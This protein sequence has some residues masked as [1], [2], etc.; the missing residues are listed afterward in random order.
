METIDVQNRSFVVRWLKVQKGDTIIFQLKPLKRSVDAGVY[1][2]QT[3]I[4]NETF[5]KNG[6]L[7]GKNGGSNSPSKSNGIIGSVHIA[8][9]TKTLLDYALNR[10]NSSSEDVTQRNRSKSIS[11]VQHSNQDVPLDKRLITQGFTQVKWLGTIP[12][13]DLVEGSFQA[14]E[15]GYYAFVLDNTASKTAKKKILLG[16]EN[17][18]QGLDMPVRRSRSQLVRVK[19]GRILQG[20]ILKKRRKKLQGFTKRFFKLDLKYKALSYYLNEHNNVCRGEIVIPLATVS[21]NKMTR[22]IIIDSGMEIWV[23]KAR[24]EST[25]SEWI[26]ALQDCYKKEEKKLAAT[27]IDQTDPSN[28]LAGLQLIEQKLDVCRINSLGYSPPTQEVKN[29]KHS[30]QTS[31]SSRTTSATSL[32]HIFGKNKENS[33]DALIGPLDIQQEKLPHSPYEHELYKKLGEVEDLV[34]QWLIYSTNVIHKSVVSED[35]SIFSDEFYDAEDDNL[36]PESESESDEGVI[37]LND[38]EGVNALLLSQNKN[39][40]R[41][42]DNDDDNSSKYDAKFVQK[43]VPGST[44]GDLYPLPCVT[45]IERRND[46]QEAVAS[47]P[48]LLSFLR[49]N[50]GKD[51]TSISM[52]ITSNEPITILQM[53]SETFEYSELLNQAAVTTDEVQRMALVA[54]FSC[55]YLSMHRSKTRA[56]RKPFNPLLG[57]TFELVREDKGMRLIAEK[58]SHKPQIFAFHIDSAQWEISYSASPVQ[59]FWGKSIEFVNEG[60]LKLTIKS[61]GERYEWSQPT[62]I[63]K[64]I[65]AG[66]RYV[67]PENHMEVVSSHNM[68]ARVAF[69]AAGMF[70]GRSEDLS[71]AIHRGSNQAGSLKG[72]WTKCISYSHNGAKIWEVGELVQNQDKKYGFT[73]FT[74]NLN[75]ITEMEK[76][77]IPVTDSRLRP[78]LRFYEDGKIEEAGQLK[79]ELEQQQRTRR[80]DSND[81]KPQYFHRVS[82]NHWELIRGPDS[83]WEKRKRG[84]W[85]NV[86]PLW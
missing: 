10:S 18:T 44:G 50:V 12:G 79:L 65:F 22:L 52:P 27:K 86:V 61:T 14:D 47:P 85:T 83:Y 32:S 68:K 2:R 41:T 48:S 53:L 30:L 77:H 72:D 45:K 17:K 54:A 64:N 23:L 51:L 69:K 46:V 55:S 3:T 33:Q 42:E 40:G 4:N 7:N 29:I 26:Q 11:A 76:D 59:K 13:N 57:E 73:Q 38:E 9:D 74:A 35:P 49:K 70:S 82:D 1:K 39:S 24:D 5:E 60:E 63:L 62:T 58:V 28:L 67:E 25:W 84:D 37:M 81:V 6:E 15:D 19:Q 8:P 56:L 20:Y 36:N 16:V 34:R 78:D 80:L 31:S 66:E 75:Q 43:S 71:I 21:A